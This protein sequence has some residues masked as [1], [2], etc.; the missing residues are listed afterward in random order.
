MKKK[1]YLV[2]G[3]AQYLNWILP[4]GFEQTNKLIGADCVFFSGGED[5]DPSIYGE[6]KN[7]AVCSNI[8]RDL[9]EQKVFNYCVDHNI[10]MIGTCRGSQFLCAMSGGILVQDQ[11]NVY[12]HPI[13]TYDGQEFICNSTH[14]NAQY[15]NRMKEGEAVLLAWST[16]ISPYHAGGNGE[17]LV[18]GVVPDN[19]ECEIVF[20]PKTKALGFQMHNEMLYGEPR[21]NNLI[22]Y[23]Q[24]LIKEFILK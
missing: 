12:L 18:N 3:S 20:Y 24:N 14:H 23:C 11:Q 13:K 7:P 19:K 10:P 21:F 4:V 22:S 6:P 17:E 9:N 8:Q 1:I 15:I 2:S 5:V 16:D